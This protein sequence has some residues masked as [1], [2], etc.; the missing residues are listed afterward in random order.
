VFCI[1]KLVDGTP[2]FP[3]GIP[4]LFQTIVAMHVAT[5]D[6]FGEAVCIVDHTVAGVAF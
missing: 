6:P 5:R 1:D 3:L 4:G 2:D